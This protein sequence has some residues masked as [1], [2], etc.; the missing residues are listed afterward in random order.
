MNRMERAAANLSGEAEHPIGGRDALAILDD[1]PTGIVLVKRNGTTRYMN[2]AAGRLFEGCDEAASFADC[3]RTT[4][5][6]DLDALLAQ[7]G[8]VEAVIPGPYL[9]R[10]V[11]LSVATDASFGDLTVVSVTDITPLKQ[12]NARIEFLA[13][14]DPLTGLGNRTLLNSTWEGVEAGLADGSMEVHALA[15]DLDH[16]K[17]VNDLHGHAIGDVLLREVAERLRAAIGASAD[18][19]RFGGDEFF[20]LVPGVD[21]AEAVRVAERVVK[22]LQAPFEVQGMELRIGCS[23]GVASGPADG[24]ARDQLHRCA[25]LALYEVKRSGR[26]SVACFEPLQEQHLLERRLLQTDLILAIANGGFDLVFQPQI[27]ADTQALHGAE[28]LLRWHNARLGRLIMPDEVIAIAEQLGLMHLV[29]LW[30]IRNAIP[31]Y[32]RLARA[33]WDCP[34]LSINLRTV[35][36]QTHEIPV[37]LRRVLAETRLDPGRI[38]IEITEQAALSGSDELESAIRQLREIGV[39]IV[40]DSFGAGRANFAF[41]RSLGVERIKVDRALTKRVMAGSEAPGVMSAIRALCHELGIEM[42]AEGVETA[43]QWQTL[44]GFGPLRGQGNFLGH[45]DSEDEIARRLRDGTE[46]DR[47]RH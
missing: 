34:V 39:R 24:L 37:A 11:M 29:D 28:T 44:R 36:L 47:R 9:D 30:V 15:L 26:G 23:I 27:D 16:F 22:L 3:V 42:T 19:F 35:S 18:I 25:D 5:G 4:S 8:Q 41:V 20:A 12:A 10:H 43:E 46:A 13:H 40:I 2:K 14:H 17:Q 21:R 38:E 7:G 45:P 33:G 31:G 1:V 6:L 32:A